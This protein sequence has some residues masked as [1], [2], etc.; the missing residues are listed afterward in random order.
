VIERITGIVVKVDPTY[1]VIETGGVGFCLLIPLST[2]SRLAQ[3][4]KTTLFAELIVR[5]DSLTLF[6]FLTE[7]ER[8]LFN[9]LRSVAGVGPK[10]ACTVLSGVTVDGVLEAV[11]RGDPAMLARV[12]GIGKKTAGRIIMELSEKVEHVLKPSLGIAPSS[13]ESI[14]ALM[15]LGYQRSVATRAVEEAIEAIG[16]DAPVER[17]IREALYLLSGHRTKRASS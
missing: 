9:L 16:S 11:T 5:E 2:S 8:D 7:H 13:S 17:I 15:S 4:E 1:A 3:G 12:P 6:G 10:L 14:Q